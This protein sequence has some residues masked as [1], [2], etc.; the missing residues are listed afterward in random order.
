[1]IAFDG[2]PM[3][4]SLN[5]DPKTKQQIHIHGSAILAKDGRTFKIFR[6]DKPMREFQ[7][8]VNEAKRLA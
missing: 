1:M 3:P 7:T 5:I 2:L 4:K 8:L 6:H